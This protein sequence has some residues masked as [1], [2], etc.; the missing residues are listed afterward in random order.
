MGS[1]IR[2][3]PSKTID[4]STVVGATG[5]IG[6]LS[7]H[8]YHFPCAIGEDRLKTCTECLY[9]TNAEV[10]DSATCVQCGSPMI[11]TKGIE[12]GQLTD[13]SSEDLKNNF[14]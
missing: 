5:N 14:F 2:I 1:Q 6:G 8:E 9:G 12:V 4:G 11:E 3:I 10:S 7:S 13:H